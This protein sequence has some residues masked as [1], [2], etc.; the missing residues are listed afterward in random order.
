MHISL[1]GL[2]LLFYILTSVS[3]AFW[4]LCFTQINARADATYAL[5]SL[6]KGDEHP[7]DVPNPVEYGTSTFSCSRKPENRLIITTV[8]KR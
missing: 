4:Q 6:G 7:T 5:S 2:L 1:I 8:I 3:F